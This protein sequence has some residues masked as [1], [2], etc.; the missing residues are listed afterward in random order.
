[1]SYLAETLSALRTLPEGLEA[2]C[3]QLADLGVAPRYPG[4]DAA[5][6]GIDVG[7]ILESARRASALLEPLATPVCDTESASE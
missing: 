2:I 4:W 3:T 1:V 7:E 6:L 5:L